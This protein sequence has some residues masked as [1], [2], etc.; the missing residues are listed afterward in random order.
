MDI[1][2]EITIDHLREWKASTCPLNVA[3][4]G[5]GLR[6]FSRATVKAVSA[7]MVV[8]SFAEAGNGLSILLHSAKRF[9]SF[10]PSDPPPP[11]VGGYHKACVLF[12]VITLQD[13]SLCKI[14]E[15]SEHADSPVILFS[16]SEHPW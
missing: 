16:D 8:F 10:L 11:D 14:C 6:V 15:L 2:L 13:G 5:Q 4:G 12:L 3:V 1:S 7:N 9:R